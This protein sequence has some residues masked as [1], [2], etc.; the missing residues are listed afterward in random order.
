M[1]DDRRTSWSESGQAGWWGKLAAGTAAQDV[2]N[3]KYHTL[4]S[5]SK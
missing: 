5:E 1:S 4:S 2:D 3:G